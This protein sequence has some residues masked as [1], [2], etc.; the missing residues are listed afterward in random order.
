[1][2]STK[3]LKRIYLYYLRIFGHSC[4]SSNRNIEYFLIFYNFIIILNEIYFTFKYC[5]YFKEN[6]ETLNLLQNLTN[7]IESFLIIAYKIARILTCLRVIFGRKYEGYIV[8]LIKEIED[9]FQLKLF[10]KYEMSKFYES[11]WFR[12]FWILDLL[13]CSVLVIYESSVNGVIEI[14]TFLLFFS[15]IQAIRAIYLQFVLFIIKIDETLENLEKCLKFNLHKQLQQQQTVGHPAEMEI[16]NKQCS[17]ATATA[18]AATPFNVGNWSCLHVRQ[19]LLHRIWTMKCIY[20]KIS[21]ISLACSS[22][23]GL[24]VLLTNFLSICE[25][26]QIMYVAVSSLAHETFPLVS[27]MYGLCTV[28]PTVMIMMAMCWVSDNCSKRVSNIIKF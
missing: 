15:T 23:F 4:H 17:F 18:A 28:L 27:V 2:Q 12:Y 11:F 24:S 19:Y 20:G 10:H 14:L 26:T 9:D 8:K 21:Q 5:V 16:F 1:M 7:L 6:V 22:L 3:I 25:L 13:T